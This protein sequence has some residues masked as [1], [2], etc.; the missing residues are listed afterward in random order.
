[1]ALAFSRRKLV[2]LERHLCQAAAGQ[3][4]E[5]GGGGALEQRFSNLGVRQRLAK[6]QAAGLHPR[7]T[8]W[9]WSGGLKICIS[10]KF[11]GEL[12]DAAGPGITL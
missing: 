2:W 3:K 9:V 8:Q 4:A 11:P 7:L 6:A 12:V 10:N 1:M 5:P